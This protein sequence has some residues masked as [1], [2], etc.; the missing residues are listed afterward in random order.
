MK[1]VDLKMTSPETKSLEVA[2]E[3]TGEH[4][5]YGM[6][7]YLDDLTLEKMGMKASDFTVGEELAIMGMGKV[8]GVSMR[9]REGGE[10]Y[11]TVDI[12]ITEVALAEEGEVEEEKAE[13]TRKSIGDRMYGEG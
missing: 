8:T 11:S 6:C 9:E 13:P 2:E 3:T 1:F 10:S 7:L 12:Q 5:P 4:Y